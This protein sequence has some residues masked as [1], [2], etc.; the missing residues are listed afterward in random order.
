MRSLYQNIKSSIKAVLSV[1]VLSSLLLVSCTDSFEGMNKNPDGISDA[2]L[3]ADYN[4]FGQPFPQIQ[5]SVYFNFG[6]GNWQYQLQQNLLGDIY[7]GYMM[8]PTPFRG[9]INNTNYFLV[10]GWNGFPF[11]LAYQNVMSQVNQV[12]KMTKDQN[13]QTHFYGVALIL[14]V[15]AMHR[16]T[17]IYGP[18][19]YS[20]FGLSDTNTPYDKQQDIYTQ[21]FAELDEAVQLL[22]TYVTANPSL[23]PFSNFDQIFSGDYKKWLKWA[24]SLRLRLAMRISY[25]DAVKSKAEFQKAVTN[26][27]GFLTDNA[28]EVVTVTGKGLTNPL[29]VINDA[30]GDIRMSAPMESFLTGYSDPRIGTYFQTSTITPGVYKGIRQGIENSSKDAYVVFSK[31]NVTNSTPILLMT[32]AEVQFLLAEAALKGYP[33]V[34]G[35]AQSYYEAGITASFKQHQVS[36]V[37]D[38]LNNVASPAAYVDPVNPANNTPAATNVTVKW[39]N[40]L[41]SE[42]QLEKIITQKWLAMF[43]EGQEAWSEFRRTGYPKLFKVQVN[44]S[45]GAI[46]TDKFIR[47]V[48]FPVTEATNNTDQYNKA[49]SMLKAESNNVSAPNNGDNGGTNLWWDKKGMK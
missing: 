7:S 45:G 14:K 26:K 1:T 42:Q 2:T 33:G 40:S 36:G 43:P 13:Q 22:D 31:L 16:V 32:P 29:G 4:L 34:S 49:V 5:Q 23:T 47:R 19:P 9:N 44:N 27:Y 25:A 8:T 21:F 48:N 38:Y 35:S 39:D 18:I 41:S 30:W 15:A 20:Q 28:S 46:S 37:S 10:D 17:D 3:A 11:S 24:N 6:N 12:K